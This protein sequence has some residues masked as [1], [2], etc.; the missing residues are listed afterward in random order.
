MASQAERMNA[1][2]NNIAAL[3]AMMGKLA[4]VTADDDSDDD[5]DVETVT[6]APA[7][8]VKA[9]KV[10]ASGWRDNAEVIPESVKR[11]RQS[12]DPNSRP[13]LDQASYA[14]HC[15][16]TYQ[17]LAKRVT[18]GIV[19]YSGVKRE[20]LPEDAKAEA[21]RQAQYAAHIDAAVTSMLAAFNLFTPDDTFDP[22][23]ATYGQLWD[24][25][26]SHAPQSLVKAKREHEAEA[27]RAA[28]NGGK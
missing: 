24:W 10:T 13:S 21:K 23:T 17:G 2:E 7:V 22:A 3:A 18:D 9:A 20:V 11:E 8:S 6:D 16:N 25:L 1:L 12:K 19:W 4:G 28:A 5:S 26:G 14:A 27:K 15:V